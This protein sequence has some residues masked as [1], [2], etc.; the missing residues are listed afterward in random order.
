MSII[1][2]GDLFF[3]KGG[4]I[5]YAKNAISG[6]AVTIKKRMKTGRKR[7]RQSEGEK[8]ILLVVLP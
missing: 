1:D 7:L 8:E 6:I 5:Y 3:L 4:E 2:W